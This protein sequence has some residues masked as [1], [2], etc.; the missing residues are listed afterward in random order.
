MRI[1]RLEEASA[2]RCI[3]YLEDGSTFPLGRKEERSLE[4]SEGRE[5]TEEQ[6]QWI[7][8]ELVFPRGRNYLICL[9]ASR[10]YTEKEV[11]DK[12]HKACYPEHIIEEILHYGRERHYLDDFR[13]AED[14]IAVRKHSKSIR[15]L[16]YQ[17]S[18]K[19]IPDHILSQIKE[20]NDRDDLMP[21][22]ERYWNRKKGTSYEKSAKTYQYFARKGYDSSMI[23]DIIRQISNM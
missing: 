14:Y 18:M 15:Q 13:Y 19:G 23:K 10:D 11:K 21:V 20:E 2:G 9:L 4:L 3:I 16:K 12:L 8:K 17:L 5:L 6:L 7:Y 22:V 1:V